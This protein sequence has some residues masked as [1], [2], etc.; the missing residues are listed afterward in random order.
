MEHGNPWRLWQGT[1]EP[2]AESLQCHS[3]R[4]MRDIS[5]G[6]YC[7][8]CLEGHP[9]KLKELELEKAFLTLTNQEKFADVS[10]IAADDPNGVAVLSPVCFSLPPQFNL[11]FFRGAYH[12]KSKLAGRSPNFK[13]IMEEGCADTIQIRKVSHKALKA[14]IK[15]LNSAEVALREKWAE[16][17][18]KSGISF[19]SVHPGWAE[20]PGVAKS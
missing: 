3:C 16:V 12:L 2:W 6:W 7:P 1:T 4:K 8:E 5:D 15:Y 17:H 14:F 13:A 18:K 11:H 19:Y 9:R 10:L 20:K